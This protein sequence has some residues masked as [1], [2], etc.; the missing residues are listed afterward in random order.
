MI[1]VPVG[2]GPRKIGEVAI[3]P[4]MLQTD[5]VLHPNFAVS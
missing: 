2:Q 3:Q 1:P 5:A 4:G